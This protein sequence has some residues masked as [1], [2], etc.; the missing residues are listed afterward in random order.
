ME[1]NIGLAGFLSGNY[2]D[3]ARALRVVVQQNPADRRSQ[4]MLAMSLYMLKDYANAAPVF[5]RIS[6]EAMADPR[7]SL[8]WAETLA[9]TKDPQGA[10]GVLA[11]L[12]EQPIP[13]EM[14][15]RAGDIYSSIGDVADAK[16]C[17]QKAREQ[18][19]AISI[20]Q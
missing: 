6:D 20:P 12:T 2:A 8:A 17:Y 19:P 7:M 10:A 5:E 9:Q 18:N 13:P 3:S 4:S 15:V 1:R 16:V 11:K 14:L